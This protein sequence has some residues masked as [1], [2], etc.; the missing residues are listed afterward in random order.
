MWQ[1]G[2]LILKKLVY[3]RYC[4]SVWK[5]LQQ[6]CLREEREIPNV[7]EVPAGSIW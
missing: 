7:V 3:Q 2:S 1:Y 6:W 4:R 5:L